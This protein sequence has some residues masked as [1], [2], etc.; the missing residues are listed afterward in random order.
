MLT[1][2]QTVMGD[3][4]NRLK[5]QELLFIPLPTSENSR[6]CSYYHD[7]RLPCMKISDYI[8]SN[9]ATSYTNP[10]SGKIWIRR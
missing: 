8:E 5:C 10:V 9:P 2:E 7:P 4:R 6:E 3:L 1:L